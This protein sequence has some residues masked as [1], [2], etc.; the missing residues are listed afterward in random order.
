[1][2]RKA[3]QQVT[4]SKGE[5]DPDLSERVDLEHYYDSLASAL[6]CVFHPQGGVSDRGGFALVSDA[7]VLASGQPRRLRRKLVPLA[8]SSGMITAANGGTP[9]YLVDQDTATVFVT[10]ANTASPFV[11]C[12][13]DLGAS[14]FVDFVD[15]LDFKSELAGSDNALAVEYWTGTTWAVFADPL[16]SQPRKHIR[17]TS[18]RRRFGPAPGGIGGARVLARYWR[19]VVQTGAGLTG[20]ITLGGLRFWQ[21]TGQLS[22]IDVREVARETGT[23]YQLV[24]S[25][26]NCDVYELQR[27]VASIPVPIAAQQVG[28]IAEAGGFD[29]KILFHEDLPTVRIVRQGSA[30]EWD[31]GLVPYA[32]VPDL[33]PQVIFSGN[34]DEIQ[35][36]AL[37]GITTGA[38][39]HLALGDLIAAPFVYADSSTL[40]GQVATAVGALPGVVGGDF[41]ISLVDAA[42]TVRLRFTSGN[43]NR[44]WPLVTAMT[45]APITPLT[46]VYQPGL[47]A[48]GPLF[49]NTSGWPRCGAFVQERL[50]VAGMRAAPTS[51]MFSRPAT[52]NFLNESDPM[53]A[54]LAFLRSLDVDGIETITTVFVGRHLQI[55][56]AASEWYVA[57]HTLDATQPQAAIR[58]SSHGIRRAVPIAFADGGSLFVQTG[59]QTMRDM[60]WSD[61]EQSYRA[62]PITV[63][64]PQIMRDVVDVAHRSARSVS[65]GNLIFMANADGSAACLTLLRGQNVVAGAPWQYAGGGLIKSFMSSVAHE[66]YAVVELGGD[67]W[68]A[69]WTKDM[70]LDHATTVNLG[71]ATQITGAHHF[72]GRTDVWAFADG[73]I[74]GPLTV[75]G[76]VIDLGVATTTA[77]YGLA[78]EWRGRLQVF[79]D[80]ISKDVPFRPPGRIYEVELA[81]KS[82]G[83]VSIGTNGNAHREVPLIRAGGILKDAGPLATEDGGAPG[84][85]MLERL[86][87]G[88]IRMHGLTGFSRHPY[89]EF[90]RSVPAP[91]HIKAMRMEIAMKD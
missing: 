29:T 91:V 41:S 47:D 66:A 61:A 38:V 84:L 33:T 11:T 72:E 20:T 8:I 76:G 24:I 57:A 6:N 32:D 52:F 26:R 59:G 78:P 36:I 21:E 90:S 69:R 16:D 81:L 63:L 58:V 46:T 13:V 15:V 54:D 31:A 74:I 5:L 44:A 19:V 80:R 53:T 2:G 48:T 37:P 25:E 70:P 79:R 71:G 18:R 22:P 85:P 14:Q 40:L 88:N 10:N 35:D 51:F 62:D 1:M 89:L 27:Y 68:L 83:A 45:S 87:T 64:S 77:V 60:L 67:H 3:T 56:T 34:Q 75:T 65:E 82:T 39:V 86:F 7:D 23:S 42:P 17:T 28:E 50:L 73:D 49:G 9:A 12:E 30:G 4:F 55:F 43:G